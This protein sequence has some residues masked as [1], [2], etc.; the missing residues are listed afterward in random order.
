MLK[1]RFTFLFR[2][3]CRYFVDYVDVCRLF[4]RLFPFGLL[5]QAERLER[6]L[7]KSEKGHHH[8][9]ADYLGERLQ[10]CF[11]RLSCLSLL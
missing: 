1:A 10:F 5:F 11:F 7:S 3:F 2:L 9:S 4:C 6:M 8:L